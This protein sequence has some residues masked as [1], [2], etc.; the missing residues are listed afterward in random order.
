MRKFKRFPPRTLRFRSLL[1]LAGAFAL[2]AAFAPRSN[3]ALIAYFNFEDAANGAN[4]DFTSEADQGLGIAT[5]IT[6][7]YGLASMGTIADFTGGLNRVAGDVDNPPNGLHS[8]G[9]RRTTNND[10]ANFDIPLLSSQGFFQNMT[11][12]F[13]TNRNGNGFAN[14]QLFYSI[15]GGAN[16][17]AVG[18]S[19]L[20]PTGLIVVTLPVPAA[21]NNA[22]LLVL[23]IQFT[24]GGPGNDLQTMVDNI[25]INGTIVPEPATIAG[26]LLGVLGLCWFQRRRLIGTLRLR[27]ASV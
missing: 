7:N 26:G 13:A 5:T 15:D 21:A 1:V 18:V 14:V 11:V 24:N 16:F 4:P 2:L 10:P 8:M 9:L 19:T 3:A 22:P 23:R 12:T 27:R 6:T 25:Q 20:L 17:T